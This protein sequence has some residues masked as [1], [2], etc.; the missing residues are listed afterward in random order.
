MNSQI[1]DI[2]TE[3]GPASSCNGYEGLQNLAETKFSGAIKT[4]ST[5]AFMLNGNVIGVADGSITA[6]DGANGTAYEAPDPSLTLLYTMQSRDK[7]EQATYYT[8]DTPLSEA[9]ETLSSGNFTGY[10]ELSEDVHSGDY[11]LV[12]YGGRSMSVAF[13]GNSRQLFTGDKAFERATDEIGIYKVY[14]SDISVIDIPGTK[15]NTTSETAAQETQNT[16]NNTQNESKTDDANGTKDGIDASKIDSNKNDPLSSDFF[17]DPP[18]ITFNDVAGMEEIKEEL[19][20][21]VIEPLKNPEKY[22]KYGLSVENGFL[23]HGPPGTGKTYITRALAG[24][25]GINYANVKGTDLISRYVGAGTENVG[26]LFEEAR[27]YTPCMIF[28]DEIDAVATEREGTGQHQMQAQMVNQL[29]EEIG[30]IND[31]DRDIVVVGSTNRLNKIDDA[32]IRSGRLSE[33]IEIGLPDADSRIAILDTHLEAPR[34]PTLLLEDFRK[35]TEGLNAADMEQVA[36]DAAR[37]AMERSGKV[38]NED[39]E[40]AIEQVR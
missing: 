19:K 29:L 27:E 35:E 38:N 23:L 4:A 39:I 30:E 21:R 24:E 15:T 9:D 20:K 3:W 40:T 10:I 37:E 36:T 16:M 11:Y 12:Y 26:K 13:I 32:L 28:I 22:K 2:I 34:S 14:S 5:W 33:H 8:K 25:L 7:E 1:K 31:K 18:E 17:S 6:F